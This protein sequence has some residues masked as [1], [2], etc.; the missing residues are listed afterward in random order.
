MHK[1]YGTGRRKHQVHECIY[2]AELEKLKSIHKMSMN[3]LSL[4]HSQHIC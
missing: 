2:T 3:L 4:Q 1:T